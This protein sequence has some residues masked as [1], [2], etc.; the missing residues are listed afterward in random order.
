MPSVAESS[1]SSLS[2]YRTFAAERNQDL[3]ERLAKRVGGDVLAK[4]LIEELNNGGKNLRPALTLA[5]YKIFSGGNEPSRECLAA[6]HALEVFHAFVLVHDDVIDHSERRRGRPTLHRRLEI[7]LGLPAQTASHLA[8]VLGDIL[9]GYA[10]DLLSA[11]ALDRSLVADL[12][13][14]LAGVTEDTGLGESLELTYLIQPLP[15]VSRKQIEEVYYLK[16]TRYT[17]EAPLW[18]GARAAGALPSDLDPLVDFA[19]PIGLGFQLENDLHEASLPR[20]EFEK[21]AYDFQTGVKTLFLRRLYDDLNHKAQE[22]LSTLLPRCADD[23]SA[24][25]RLHEL[26]HSTST[27]KTMKDEVDDCFQESRDWIP[28]SPFH[29]S[30]QHGLHGLADLVF[31]RRRH[32]ESV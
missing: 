24:L 12:Q 13:Q 30:I 5:A 6:A 26:I 11:P 2:V 27:L 22:E 32:S 15:E 31:T 3:A 7:D 29:Q 9:F 18:L 14:Y 28:N 8:I 23:P 25:D 16:T 1:D 10:I 4:P 21:R 19:R 17:I 20:D